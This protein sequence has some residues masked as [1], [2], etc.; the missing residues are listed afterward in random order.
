ML[1][2]A[3][4]VIRIPVKGIVSNQ[5]SANCRLFAH[6]AQEAV[7]T[8]ANVAIAIAE[9]GVTICKIDHLCTMSKA[10]IRRRGPIPRKRIRE[11]SGGDGGGSRAR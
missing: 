10:F 2:I 5:P 9:E 11:P 7:A 3:T 6:Q 8:V 4:R 1:A